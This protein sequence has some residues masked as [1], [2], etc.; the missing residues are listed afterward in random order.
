MLKRGYPTL[1]ILQASNM[2]NRKHISLENSRH[3]GQARSEYRL[4]RLDYPTKLRGAA[5]FNGNNEVVIGGN[6]QG[7]AGSSVICGDSLTM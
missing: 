2:H 7:M 3:D 4:A 1:Q 6:A 5:S